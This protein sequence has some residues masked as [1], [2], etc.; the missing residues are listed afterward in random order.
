VVCLLKKENKRKARKN[1]KRK[2]Y[3]KEQVKD[4]FKP[5]NKKFRWGASHITGRGSSVGS[6]R[7]NFSM[8]FIFFIQSSTP[9]TDHFP[10][11]FPAFSLSF[12]FLLHICMLKEGNEGGRPF[13]AGML[14]EN[15]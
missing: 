8:G 11:I 4:K 14:T 12:L 1:K 9:S 3:E 13:P 5:H 2:V 6:T 15:K 7:L 10:H